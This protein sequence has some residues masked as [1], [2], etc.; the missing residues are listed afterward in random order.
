MKDHWQRVLILM[1]LLVGLNIVYVYLF[2][3]QAPEPSAEVSYSFFKQQLKNGM[4]AAVTMQDSEL[5]GYFIEKISLTADQ[6]VTGGF[7][8]ERSFLRFHTVLPPVDDPDLLSTLE[9]QNVSLVAKPPEG[10]SLWLTIVINLLPWVII[11]GVWWYIINRMRQQGG[12]GGNFLNR[13]SKSGA[14]LYMHKGAVITF[15]NVAGLL[16]AKQELQEIIAYL[17]SPEKFARL[18]GKVPRGVLL[19]GPP[20]TGKTLMARAVAGEANV[21]FF[22]I[23]AS[24]FIEMF[25]GV[26]ASRVRDLFNG[27][28]KN[29]PS[30]IFVDELDA[31]GRARG[32]GLGGGH[33]EREQTLNQ[34]LSELDGFT[35]HDEVIVLA[36]TNRPDVL[37]TAL[38]RPGRFDRMVIIERPDWRDRLKILEVHTK[39]MP[40]SDD[41]DLEYIAKGTPGMVGADLQGIVN[42]AA[43][44]AARDDAEKVS[45]IHFERAKDRQLM[46][47]ERKLLMSEEETW[48][49]AIHESGHALVAC[50]LPN[51]DPV[52]KITIIPRGQALGMTQQL[53]EDDRYHFRRSYLLSR[54]AVML[55]GRAAELEFFEEFSSGAQNDLKQVMELAERMVCQWGMSERLGPLS[56]PRGEEHPFLGRR[57]AT[58]KTFSDRTAWIIDQEIKNIALAAQDCATEIV[59]QNRDVLSALAK[60]L[61][62]DE[63]LDRKQLESF[64]DSYQLKTPNAACRVTAQK[65]RQASTN[66]A[67]TTDTAAD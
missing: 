13:F 24:Q 23:S 35:P 45:M 56:Y 48:S 3:P 43:L 51:T 16:E 47:M 60:K 38:L 26:G 62:T 41:V 25:V 12:M 18:G 22:S 42:E 55:G 33:D 27:A 32:T 59:K 1:A 67:G 50:C 6:V 8:G 9:K 57:L 21:P 54:M 65:N 20:G 17:K 36:A 61:L 46:G 63:T 11:I 28:K 7:E 40:L 34:L 2:S 29:A 14:Q 19:A 44:I 37:D 39:E 53:P 58:E 5:S 10:S 15:E 31:V 52:H 4:V 66:S 64:F 49:T 30:I